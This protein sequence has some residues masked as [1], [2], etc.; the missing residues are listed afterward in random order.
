MTNIYKT[1]IE[2]YNN[3]SSKYSIKTNMTISRLF[4]DENNIK[5]GFIE[6]EDIINFEFDTLED[7]IY[8]NMNIEK[9]GN[10]ELKNK[11]DFRLN[12]TIE[13]YKNRI[14]YK[15]KWDLKTNKKKIKVKCIIINK[16]NHPELF[17]FFEKYALVI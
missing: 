12:H 13:K 14:T 7:D 4:K 10:L 16:I 6:K 11:N 8:I 5:L 15:I 17:V 9:I 1:L 2:F 3:N